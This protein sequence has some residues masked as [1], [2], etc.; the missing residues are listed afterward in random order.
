M[1]RNL[2]DRIIATFV[3]LLM[4]SSLFSCGQTNITPD[5]ARAIAKE[6]YIY[7]YPMVDSYRIYYSYFVDSNDPEFKAPWNHLRNTPRVYGP[8]DKTIQTPNSDTP[9]S[10]LG[11]DLRSEPIVITVPAI[12]KDRYYSIQLIDA[13]TH[14]FD[15]IGTR[16]T[17]NESGSFL[18][19]GPSWKGEKPKGIKAVFKS[20]T[21]F[22][23]AQYRTQLI[24]PSDLDNV[25]KVQAG[26][27]VQTLSKF[28]GKPA[29]KAASEI[30]F[31]KP[32]SHDQLRN[33]F[34]F[35]D[36]LNF[37][38]GFCQTH[39]S[40]NDLM[41]RFAKLGIGAGRTFNA[42]ELLPELQQAVSDGITD[43]WKEFD[44][45]LAKVNSG[46]LASGDVF[47]TRAFMNNNYANRMA[48]AVLGI[49]GNSKQEAM[50]P[51]YY[52]DAAGQPPDASKSRYVLRFP[53]GQ[54][55][56]V[57]AFWSLTMYMMP[58]RLLV[59]NPLNRYLVNSPALPDYKRDA[60]GGLTFYIQHESPG[61]NKE[62]NWLPAPNGPFSMILRMYWPKADALDGTWKQPQLTVN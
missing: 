32:I 53:P 18:V 15:Y 21:D 35:F 43:A 40:E 3:A 20:E 61:K 2:F 54:L 1:I 33:S 51:T 44:G 10:A 59:E 24:N 29:P 22:G 57:N 17:G 62:T 30:E 46:E 39:P 47:G 38:L 26:Y 9:Y 5:E 36:I 11:L 19:A 48:A 45:V 58:E 52:L 12:D 8:E 55:P 56:P 34:E 6:A 42:S 27:K 37:T 25:K 4:T 14:N 13:Y 28:L 60:D 49:F 50:Y 23:W 31:I 16:A 7:G 41:E